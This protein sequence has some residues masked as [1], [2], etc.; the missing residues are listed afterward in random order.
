MEVGKDRRRSPGSE[1]KF[2]EK[3]IKEEAMGLP[4]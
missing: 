2:A 4:G 1:D 3:R